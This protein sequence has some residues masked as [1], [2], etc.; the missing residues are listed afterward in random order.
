MY[1]I[2]Y[3]SRIEESVSGAHNPGDLSDLRIYTGWLLT[4]CQAGSSSMQGKRECVQLSVRVS[5]KHKQ[6]LGSSL[7]G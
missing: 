5:L 4:S 2:S 7:C 3:I 1:V 6:P